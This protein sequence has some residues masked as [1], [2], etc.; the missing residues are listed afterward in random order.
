[1]VAITSYAQGTPSWSEL[2]TTAEKEALEFYAALF[3]W[4]D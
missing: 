4:V 1:M 3:G 2:S